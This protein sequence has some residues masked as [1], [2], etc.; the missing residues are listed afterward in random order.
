MK[1]HLYHLLA[2]VLF[3]ATGFSSVASATIIFQFQSTCLSNCGAIGGSAGD[4]VSGTIGFADAAIVPGGTVTTANITSL[5]LHFGTFTFGLP[6]LGRFSGVLN[7]TALAFGSNGV[8]TSALGT[9]PGY[10]VQQAFWLAGPSTLNAASGGGYTLVR[11]AAVPEPSVL[12]LIALGL[13]G[14]GWSPRW[15]SRPMSDSVS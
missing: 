9:Q 3:A 7:P 11:V 5:N 12:A 1:G 2:T 6:T 15:R 8:F 14:L 4:A 13:V 10:G